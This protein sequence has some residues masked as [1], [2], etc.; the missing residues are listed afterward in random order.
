MFMMLK[1]DLPFM[2]TKTCLSTDRGCPESQIPFENK[3]S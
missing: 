1:K 3:K 2:K